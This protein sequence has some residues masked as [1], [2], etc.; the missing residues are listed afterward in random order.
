MSSK[1]R[2]RPLRGFFQPEAHIHL[3]VQ[4]LRRGEMPTRL[5]GP[6]GALVERTETEMTVGHEWTHTAGLGER[7]RLAVQG[8]GVLGITRLQPDRDVGEQ[9]HGMRREAGMARRELDRE[10]RKPARLADP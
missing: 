4:R 3:A 1:E 6:A 7:Q 8:L 2:Y 5:I 9:V 10:R